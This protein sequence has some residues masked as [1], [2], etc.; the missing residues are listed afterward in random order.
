[1]L[2]A[3]RYPEYL[4]VSDSVVHRKTSSSRTSCSSGTRVAD[5]LKRF[6]PRADPS[7]DT[8]ALVLAGGRGSRLHPLTSTCCKPAVPFGGNLR[9]IDFALSNCI[10]SGIAQVGVLTQYEQHSL[11]NHVHDAWNFLRRDLNEFVDILPAQQHLEASWYKGTADAVFQNRLLLQRLAPRYTLI[12]A[13]DHIY[14][15]DYRRMIHRHC[16]TG[17]GVTVACCDRPV[18]SASQ[19]GVLA[20]SEQERITRFDEKPAHPVEIPGHPGYARVS[21]GVYLFDTKLLLESLLQDEMDAASSHDFARDIIPS[22]IDTQQVYA[23]GFDQAQDE[24]Y[25][26]DVGTVDAYY[27]AHMQLLDTVPSLDLHD[28]DW[29]IHTRSG[30][31]RPARFISDSRGYGGLA[32]DC[33]IASGCLSRGARLRHC[34]LFTDALVDEETEIV[35]SLILPGARV[36]RNCRIRNAIIDSQTHVPDGTDIG[37][38]EQLDALRHHR[39]AQGIVVVTSAAVTSEPQPVSRRSGRPCSA[40]R[41]PLAAR[42]TAVRSADPVDRRQDQQTG[43]PV[44]TRDSRPVV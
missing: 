37:Y 4:Q 43:Q 16:Q 41:A 24:H 36:G 31:G 27:D 1:M 32:S 11:I 39:T 22:L 18:A 12:V 38:D 29:P 25:W 6:S 30:N 3:S 2:P 7:L 20:T 10:N 14:K 9:I 40:A 42:P 8:G 15:C 21:M 44:E 35:N 23:Y 33:I 17:A 34:V 26:R 28:P 19:F 13:G 5:R